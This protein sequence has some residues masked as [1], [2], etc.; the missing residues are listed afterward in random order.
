MSDAT[1]PDFA[2]N[3]RRARTGCCERCGRVPQHAEVTLRAWGP[4]TPHS[5]RMLCD[6]CLDTAS[7]AGMVV[8]TRALRR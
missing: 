3:P 1:D 5:T 6:A 2:P 8:R 7:R 4:F